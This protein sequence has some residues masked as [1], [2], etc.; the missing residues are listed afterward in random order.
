MPSLKPLRAPDLTTTTT[1]STIDEVERPWNVVV[2]NDPVTP[3]QVVVVVFKK[4]FG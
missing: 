3:M 4:I 1:T 2:W